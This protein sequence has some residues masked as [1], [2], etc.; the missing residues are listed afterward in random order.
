MA[1]VTFAPAI[2]RHV[3]I[4]EQRVDGATVHD[5]LARCISRAPALRGYLFNDQG[6]LRPHVAVF[7]DGRL[8]RDRRALSDALG[9]A[10]HVY[11]AQAL[12]GG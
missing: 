2:Q 7:V 11:V 12:S 8:I 10:S 1:T 6:R 9:D 5:A 4:D 3:P